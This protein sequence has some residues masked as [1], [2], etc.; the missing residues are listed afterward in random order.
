MSP[1]DDCMIGAV[2]KVSL[3]QKLAYMHEKGS[4]RSSDRTYL[5]AG[6]LQSLFKAHV[7]DVAIQE[8]LRTTR[9]KQLPGSRDAARW[10]WQ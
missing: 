6:G 2:Q 3:Q 5:M 9:L 1:I 10:P 8:L 7:A 4:T